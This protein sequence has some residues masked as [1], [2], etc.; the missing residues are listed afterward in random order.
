MAGMRFSHMVG[1]D[2]VEERTGWAAAIFH[3]CW[4]VTNAEIIAL[5]KRSVI[6]AKAVAKYPETLHRKDTAMLYKLAEIEQRK[7]IGR[8]LDARDS[9]IQAA[10]GA[11]ALFVN[12]VN[13]END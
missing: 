7:R 4:Y 3:S 1:V 6:F 10:G 11:I 9:L 8:T 13:K 2:D 5:H 12:S